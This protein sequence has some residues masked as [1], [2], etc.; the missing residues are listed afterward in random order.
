MR[1]EKPIL[2]APAPATTQAAKRREIAVTPT[3]ERHGANRA[4]ARTRPAAC[5]AGGSDPYGAPAEF[6]A[7]WLPGCVV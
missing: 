2:S 7:R 5:G 3:M 1:S 4:I 6:L